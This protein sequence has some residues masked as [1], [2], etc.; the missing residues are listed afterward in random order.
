MIAL[1]CVGGGGVRGVRRG[2]EASP[3]PRA[4]PLGKVTLAALP[5][6]HTCCK[7]KDGWRKEL[8]KGVNLCFI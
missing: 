4:A 8:G 3:W 2:G 5:A 6:H 7:G 1:A